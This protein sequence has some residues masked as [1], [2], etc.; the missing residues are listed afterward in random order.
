MGDGKI[1]TGAIIAGIAIMLALSVMP[2]DARHPFGACPPSLD[3]E[4]VSANL[5]PGMDHNG[6]NVIC[7][8]PSL[9]IFIDDI[10]H[11]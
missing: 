7:F 10:D 2:A 9:Q 1:L 8:S 11:P 6:N 4:I 3:W 5:S